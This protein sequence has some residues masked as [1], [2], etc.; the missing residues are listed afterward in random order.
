[1]TLPQPGDFFLAPIPGN[2][3]LGIRFG[4]FLNGEGF[5][6]YQ[7]AGILLEDGRTIEAMPGGAIIGRVERW[8]P[9]QLIW[10][11]GLIELTDLQRA[12][13]LQYGQACRGIPYSFA[14]YAAIVAHRFHISTPRLQ[15]FISDSD[16]M[17]CSQMVDFIY[18]KSGKQLF[19]DGRWPGFVSP[20]SLYWLLRAQSDHAMGGTH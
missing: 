5:L 9:T 13:I 12:L 2:V 18:R 3:G 8:K 15:K 17:I 10:S 19:D 1:M 20:A 4:Q 14:D 16:H 6:P 7:H 11:S